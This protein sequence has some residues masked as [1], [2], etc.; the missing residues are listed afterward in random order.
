[1]Q[2]RAIGLVRGRYIASDEQF[3]RGIL[4]AED[5]TELNAVLLGQVMS[6]VKKHL[7]LG[8]D[9]LWVVYPRTR[10][11]QR[12]LHVQIVGVWEPEKLHKNQESETDPINETEESY[13]LSEPLSDG[14]FSVRGEV[15]F[16]SEDHGFV[17]VKIQQAPRKSTDKPKAFKLRLEGT[18]DFKAPGYFWN[19]DAR[20][21]ENALIIEQGISVALI[22]P[23]KRPVR[24]PG[25]R[26]R[27]QK[28]VSPR[29]SR[30]LENKFAA[31]PPPRREPAAKPIK[32]Q[33]HPATGD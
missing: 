11:K 33:N 31:S 3:N 10:E 29:P 12:S 18:L 15:I 14:Y 24:K 19:I 20:R 27:L 1:M 22:P 32:R 2:Y 21:Q 30:P 4:Q 8:Q 17:V 9:H 13:A 16:Q 7:D 6:L 26:Q 28:R 25:D 5:G 23:K